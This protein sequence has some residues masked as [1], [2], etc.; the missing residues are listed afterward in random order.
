MLKGNG[1]EILLSFS[2]EKLVLYPFVTTSVLTFYDLD[3]SDIDRTIEQ[4]SWFQ[5]NF[6]QQEQ[7]L[8][9][10]KSFTSLLLP[11]TAVQ[12]FH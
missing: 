6:E 3:R 8:P 1:T 12:H 4:H 10:S 2:A 7:R 11:R 5:Q 9:L